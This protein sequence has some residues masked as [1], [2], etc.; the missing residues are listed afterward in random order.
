[1][2]SRG[3]RVC[4]C[5]CRCG[6]VGGY[7]RWYLLV[8]VW[9]CAKLLFPSAASLLPSH[10]TTPLFLPCSRSV[11]YQGQQRAPELD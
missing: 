4:R 1:M 8:C 2:R 7:Q 5:V 11:S 10:L 3:L 9:T 6:C